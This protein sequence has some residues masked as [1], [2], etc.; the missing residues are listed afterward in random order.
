MS[1]DFSTA[2][3]GDKVWTIADGDSAINSLD[4]KDKLCIKV[5]EYWYTK[6]GKIGELD[7]MQSLFWSNPNIIA[8]EKPKK[9]VKHEVLI[10][11]SLTI[12]STQDR[13]LI[14]SF[15]SLRI[16]DTINIKAILYYET[17]E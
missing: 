1:Q 7:K 4:P 6:D 14:V 10:P 15:N 9:V 11:T 2:K 13:S 3:V 8:P 12:S 16:P 17:L 5:G